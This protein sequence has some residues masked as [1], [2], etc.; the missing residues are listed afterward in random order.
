MKKT[1]IVATTKLP[2]KENTPLWRSLSDHSHN[3]NVDVE[4]ITNNSTGLCEVYNRYINKPYETIIFAHDDITIDSVNFISRVN[5]SLDEYDVVGV[6]GGGDAISINSLYAGHMLWHI[7]TNTHEQSG[8]VF[9]PHKMYDCPVPAIF[10]SRPKGVI[11]LD[12][13]F[14]AIN[15]KKIQENNIK[16][17]ENLKGFH[18]YD[19]KFCLDCYDKGL[20]LGTSD[21]NII[22]Q[23][24]GLQTVTTDFVKSS[25]YV[26]NCLNKMI[27]NAE[28]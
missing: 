22:H 20:K 21:I 5:K 11:I 13:L 14:L 7:M 17:D 23:S 4:F 10:G 6:A 15:A 18:H 27:R 19:I 26:R 1:L 12:G 25:E 9:H 28:I 2:S 16:F 3:E 24:P 8:I